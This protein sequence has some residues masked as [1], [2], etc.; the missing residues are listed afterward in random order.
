MCCH[1]SCVVSSASLFCVVVTAKHICIDDQGTAATARGDAN[2]NSN[3]LSCLRRGCSHI[4]RASLCDFRQPIPSAFSHTADRN[5]V[6]VRS[7]APNEFQCQ[8]GLIA[9]L[10]VIVLGTLRQTNGILCGQAECLCCHR[11]L[12][13]Y[14]ICSSPSVNCIMHCWCMDFLTTPCALSGA[15][16]KRTK[17]P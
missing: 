16:K 9:S 2:H 6:T 5:P 7:P 12:L 8:K 14:D 15:R 11:I 13:L 4:L 1:Q 10:L 3:S 17:T